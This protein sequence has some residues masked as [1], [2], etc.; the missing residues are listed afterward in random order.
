MS[1]TASRRNS[2]FDALRG[3]AAVL[4]LL[5]HVTNLDK[6]PILPGG[7][8]AV[9]LFF[10]L[11]GFVLW[12]A[13]GD[14]LT[15]GLSAGAFVRLRLVRL[16]P[17]FAIGVTL[18]IVRAIG[19]IHLG[20]PRAPTLPMLGLEIGATALMIPSGFG[21]EG[22]FPLDNPAWSLAL[23][24]IVNIVFCLWMVRRGP[25]SL[26]AVVIVAAAGLA[27]VAAHFGSLDVGWKVANAIGGPVRCAFS[28]VAGV[29]MARQR[30]YVRR[31]SSSGLAMPVVVLT[32]FTVILAIDPGAAFR[33]WYDLACVIFVF[34]TIVALTADMRVGP[35][36]ARIGTALGEMSY[37]LYATH[38]PLILPAML[39]CAKLHLAGRIESV[40]IAA[41]CIAV[42]VAL[43]PVDRAARGLL[44]RRRAPQPGAPTTVF[45]SMK[46]ARP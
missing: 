6:R 16:Y 46:S 27:L 31:A 14:R 38:Y 17:L 10:L 12:N 43:V 36:A 34:P 20:D 42:A 9:D 5:F 32:L 2:L 30:F 33:P 44:A 19:A 41:G 35:R 24:V 21:A 37:P 40:A 11:S 23:E 39:V 26:G 22:V 3:L 18:G 28:F 25:R 7:Y 13:Y 29:V 15:H 4:V 1:E 45:T 8:L